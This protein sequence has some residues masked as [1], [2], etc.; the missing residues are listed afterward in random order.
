MTAGGQA[1][2]EK[3]QIPAAGAFTLARGIGLQNDDGDLYRYRD[4]YCGGGARCTS[5][6]S[7]SPPSG[8][9][10]CYKP[11]E[12]MGSVDPDPFSSPLCGYSRNIRSF[13]T[14]YPGGS[15]GPKKHQKN[16]TKT[17]MC[18]RPP[19]APPAQ[20]AFAA[21]ATRGAA[22]LPLQWLVGT[23]RGTG[24]GHYPTIRTQPPLLHIYTI[25]GIYTIIYKWYIYI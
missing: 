7:V 24:R 20:V 11:W 13:S 18:S 3:G 1:R 8:W 6:W 10:L 16:E 2:N 17:K 22:P 23:W 4:G 21:D 19:Q 12:P 9:H 25:N 14:H 5:K 15:G